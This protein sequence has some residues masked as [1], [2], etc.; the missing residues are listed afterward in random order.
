MKKLNKKY[1]C[2][3]NISIFP[4]KT[5]LKN[6][7]SHKSQI[8]NKVTGWILVGHIKISSKHKIGRFFNVPGFFSNPLNITSL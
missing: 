6:G 1:V 5:A 3:V 2:Q 4:M 7:K 8:N